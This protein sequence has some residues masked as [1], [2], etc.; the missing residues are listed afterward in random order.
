MKLKEEEITET[1][2]IDLCVK[3]LFSFEKCIFI[4]VQEKDQ[5]KNV[6]FLDFAFKYLEL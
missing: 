3:N 4:I 6:S 2:I 1:F 5:Q